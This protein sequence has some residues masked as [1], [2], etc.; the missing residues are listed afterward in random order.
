[1]IP[2]IFY[3]KAGGKQR[4][5]QILSRSQLDHGN[6]QEVVDEILKDDRK[7]GDKALFRYTK[8]FDQV[9][10]DALSISVSKEEMEYAY[11]QVDKELLDVIRRAAERIRDFHQKQKI[12]SW[13]E[14]SP[15]AELLGQLIRPLERVGVYVPGGKAAYP[16]SV[17][18]NV[19]PA[20]VAGVKE[21]IMATPT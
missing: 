9:E 12:N 11:T 21:I 10:L 7:N 2:I 13:L 18:M 19:I 4:I 1:M 5:E 14:P 20:H 15:N 16:S 8:E 3:H 17:L 6:V